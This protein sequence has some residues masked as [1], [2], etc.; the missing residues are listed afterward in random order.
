MPEVK[1]KTI[2]VE[3]LGD[4][5]DPTDMITITRHQFREALAICLGALCESRPDGISEKV[6]DVIA[7]VCATF[8]AGLEYQLFDNDDEEES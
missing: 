1:T 3:L 6:T 2:E 5:G 4:G 7:E 8:V